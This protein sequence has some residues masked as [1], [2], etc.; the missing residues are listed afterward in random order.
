MI[1]DREEIKAESDSVLKYEM[2]AEGKERTLIV[3]NVTKSDL[4]S[5]FVRSGDLSMETELVGVGS[6]EK[7]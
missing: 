6:F 4:G 3:K 5:Y 7:N 2:I 1:L